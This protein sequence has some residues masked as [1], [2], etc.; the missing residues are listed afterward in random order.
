MKD[1]KSKLKLKVGSVIFSLLSGKTNK[2][3]LCFLA[4]LRFANDEPLFQFSV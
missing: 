3:S 4:S 2:I 1:E